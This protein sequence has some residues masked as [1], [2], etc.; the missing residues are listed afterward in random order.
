MQ[1]VAAVQPLARKRLDWRIIA[2]IV[3][4]ALVAAGLLYRETLGPQSTTY[5]VSGT[6]HS[7]VIAYSTKDGIQEVTVRLPWS[8]TVQTNAASLTAASQDDHGTITCSIDGGGE[9][10]SSGPYANVACSG[11]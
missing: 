1:P 2:L 4:A 11:G 8:I 10:T 6:V 5:Q 3:G 9:Q 7:A